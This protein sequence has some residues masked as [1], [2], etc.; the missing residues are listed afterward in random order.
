MSQ[1]DSKSVY[2]DVIMEEDEA[3]GISDVSEEGIIEIVAMRNRNEEDK[4]EDD[5]Q[6][7]SL[8]NKE[9]GLKDVPWATLGYS[10]VQILYYISNCSTK[11]LSLKECVYPVSIGKEYFPTWAYW[12]VGCIGE[13]KKAE[14]W[15]YA[16]S[17]LSHYGLVHLVSNNI[18]ILLLG[19]DVEIMHGSLNMC[20]IA[21][22]GHVIGIWIYQV[23]EYTLNRNRVVVGS[24]ISVYALIGA[25]QNNILMNYDSMPMLEKKL[26]LFLLLFII[27][28]DIIQYFVLYND[29]VAHIGHF[30]GYLGGVFISAFVLKNYHQTYGEKKLM[31]YTKILLSTVIVPS[32]LLCYIAPLKQC[33]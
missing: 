13:N 28:N 25:R 2:I 10:G 21:F 24:S 4:V 7:F 15:R 8:A 22:L 31:K 12:T 16:T 3:L 19:S 18:F 27:I 26:R 14:L 11:N 1:H 20:Y 32:G 5:T 29:L 30:G 9:L 17:A 6:I 33:K 23:G